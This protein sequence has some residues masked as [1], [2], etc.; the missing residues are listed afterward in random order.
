MPKEEEWDVYKRLKSITQL[1]EAKCQ[2]TTY[3]LTK[4]LQTILPVIPQKGM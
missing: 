2:M 1:F 4:K 3:I